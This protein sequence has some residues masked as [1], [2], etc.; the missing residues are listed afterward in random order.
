MTATGTIRIGISGWTYAPWRGVFY[1]PG[2]A[3]RKELAFAAEHFPSIEINGTFY[4]MQR[5]ENFA[6]WSE[7][8][9]DDFVFSIKGPRYITHLK[10]LRDIET[11]LANFFASGVLRLEQKLGPILWQ[12]SP[13][14]AYNPERFETFFALLPTDT[15]QASSL[16][17]RHDERLAGRAWTRA[18][19]GQHIRHAVEIRHPSF[20]NEDFIAQ[21]RRYNI[22]LVCADAVAWPRLMD[23]TADFVYCRLHGSEQLYASGYDA[24]ALA[25]WADRVRA[26]AQGRE[27]ANAERVAGPTKPRRG[28]R[29]VFLYFDNDM[30]VRAPF[31]AAA[32]QKLLAATVDVGRSR[33]SQCVASGTGKL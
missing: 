11:P 20:L 29:D 1:P 13:R 18:A 14:T 9:P 31:D 8:T 3:A 17:T 5:P 6:H 25:A 16:A 23:L 7:E 26:W 30:K 4:R 19:P 15:E 10:Q 22:A 27:P 12:F 2:L 33:A 32:L 24:D 28:G 21:L